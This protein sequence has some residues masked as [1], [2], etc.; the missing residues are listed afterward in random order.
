M[1][2]FLTKIKQKKIPTFEVSCEKGI[3]KYLYSFG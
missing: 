1:Q 3:T 2:V